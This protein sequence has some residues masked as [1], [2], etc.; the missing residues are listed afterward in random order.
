MSFTVYFGVFLIIVFLGFLLIRNEARPLFM[1]LASYAF[2]AWYSKRALIV[3][4]I[5]SILTWLGGL[6]AGAIK[7]R[8]FAGKNT[9]PGKFRRAAAGAFCIAAI[10]LINGGKPD[11]GLSLTG[12]VLLPLGF[13]YYILQTISYLSDVSHGVIPAEKNFIRV[14]LYQV[15]FPKF[16][17]GPVER[18]GNLLGQFKRIGENRPEK[19]INF[20]R[21]VSYILTGF[22]MK[23]VIADRAGIYA[24]RIFARYGE[25]GAFWLMAGAVL[26]T[27]QIYHDFAGYSYLAVGV[28]EL[29]GI[30]LTCNFLTP[31]LAENISDFWRRWHISLSRWLR[32]YI[33]I[34][35]GGNRCSSLQKYANLLIV[36]LVSGIWHGGRWNYIVWGLLHG[37][38]LIAA[39]FL[40]GTRVD[41]MLRGMPGRIVTFCTVSFAWIFF[42]S[43][44]LGSALRYVQNMIMHWGTMEQIRA[45]RISI[46]VTAYEA[47][48]FVVALLLIFLLEIRA[49]ADGRT[50]PDML[51]TKSAA[52]RMCVYYCFIVAMAVFGIYGSGLSESAFLY[53]Q[54]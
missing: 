28:S 43:E 21:A 37:V 52:A 2:C 11:S 1:L 18:A 7:E 9:L 10:V 12:T 26:Y 50:V 13:S 8:T 36:F 47:V 48:I 19:E 24:D 54:Y 32:D 30:H 53:M 20:Y 40:Q 45:E 15:W 44:S 14:A 41:R 22:F 42:R 27:L 34:P 6:A 3:V 25:L 17:C 51:L 4:F 29:F 33:Y 49:N 5:T 31:Y 39:D 38:C 46:G 16:L 23:L 35:L